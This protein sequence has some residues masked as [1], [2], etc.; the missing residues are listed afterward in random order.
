MKVKK[1]KKNIINM[2]QHAGSEEQKKEGLVDLPEDARKE[3]SELLT[4]SSL[5][6]REEIKKRAEAIIS[7]ALKL[8]NENKVPQFEKVMIGGAPYLMASLEKE[9]KNWG[10]IPVYAFSLRE[11]VEKVEADG[12]ITKTAVFRHKGFVEVQ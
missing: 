6:T 4:F 5:P 7:L 9:I 12:S 8:R 10:Y 3:L 2:T 11:S 1:M